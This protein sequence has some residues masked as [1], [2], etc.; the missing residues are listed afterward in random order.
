MGCGIVVVKDEIYFDFSC[1]RGRV[2]N[3]VVV[4]VHLAIIFTAICC[5]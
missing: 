2:E 4:H 5:C 3:V 1:R